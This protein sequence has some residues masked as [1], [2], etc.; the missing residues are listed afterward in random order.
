MSLNLQDCNQ[1]EQDSIPK[2]YLAYCRYCSTLAVHTA[3][4]ISTMPMKN[5]LD[6]WLNFLSDLPHGLQSLIAL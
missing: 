6:S 4:T 5:M 2:S 3:A 1:T